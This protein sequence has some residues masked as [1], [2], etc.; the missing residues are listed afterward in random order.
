MLK[1]NLVY[2]SEDLDKKIN[3]QKGMGPNGSDTYNVFLYKG[4]VNC[5]HFW[6]REIYLKANNKRISVNGAIKMINLMEPSE[7]RNA[8]WEQNPKEVAQ[9]ADKQNNWWRLKK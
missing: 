7:R 5:N 2:K 4:G 1:A 3:T 6:K 9:A 8:K